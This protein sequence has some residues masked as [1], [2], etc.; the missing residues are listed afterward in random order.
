ML[1]AITFA[2][3]HGTAG[4]E[5]YEA[6]F[7]AL[8]IIEPALTSAAAK[9]VILISTVGQL[10]CGMACVTSA[11][12]MTF[13]FSRDGAIPGHNLWRRLGPNKTPDL[14]GAVRRVCAR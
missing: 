10:F 3:P 13:A 4:T 2:I 11:S 1:L 6:G 12:R 14:V 5:A 8:A 9:A 7:P